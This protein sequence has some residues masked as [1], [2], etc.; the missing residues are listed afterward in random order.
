MVTDAADNNNLVIDISK[1]RSAGIFGNEDGL[2]QRSA[3]R[4]VERFIG[5]SVGK[6]DAFQKELHKD[7]H[8]VLGFTRVHD[9]ILI[10]G[11]RGSGKTSFMHSAIKHL[12]EKPPRPY[13][14][15]KLHSLGVIDPT[16][17]SSREHIFLL[18]ISKIRNAVENHYSKE[19]LQDAS[20]AEKRDW[21]DQL[22]NLSRG[23][24][25]Q[26][27]IGTSPLARTEWEDPG[28]ILAEGLQNAQGGIKLER[29]FHRFVDSS[30]KILGAK[31][32]L[33]GI[34]DTDTDF[35]KGWPVLE[36]LRKFLTTPQLIILLSGDYDMYSK[37]VRRHQWEQFKD[38]PQL[39]RHYGEAHLQSAVEQLE[40]QYLI[41]LL[42]PP[43]RIDLKL[44]WQL[45]D[46]LYIK[47]HSG[48]KVL[49]R[50]VMSAFTEIW[51]KFPQSICK[52][53]GSLFTHLPMRNLMN[54][55]ILIEGNG[56][57]NSTPADDKND[58]TNNI[59][60]ARAHEWAE[61]E[62]HD[63][64]P[65]NIS[66]DDE[67]SSQS[68]LTVHSSLIFVHFG[69]LVSIGF[70]QEDLQA[71]QW[72]G[73]FSKLAKV[74][75]DR[76]LLKHG[77]DLFPA[78]VMQQD[79]IDI[80]ILSGIFMSAMLSDIKHVADYYIRVL[81]VRDFY[82]YKESETNNQKNKEPASD[83][84]N[85]DIRID[86][87]LFSQQNSLVDIG[88]YITRK[89][90]YLKKQDKACK[91]ESKIIITFT[92]EGNNEDN[93]F[94]PKYSLLSNRIISLESDKPYLIPIFNSIMLLDIQTEGGNDY[95]FYFS[96]YNLVAL[97]GLCIGAD[98]GLEI[99]LKRFR[100]P[101][102]INE[103][104]TT[105][106]HKSIFGHSAINY[107]TLS[108]PVNKIHTWA[109]KYHKVDDTHK[110]EKLLLPPYVHAAIWRTFIQSWEEKDKS[111][112]PITQAKNKFL[113]AIK[114]EEEQ[115]RCKDADKD[116]VG[117][118]GEEQ[119]SGKD[120]DGHPYY[121]FVKACPLWDMLEK[122]DTILV[123]NTK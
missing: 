38:H 88:S 114:T 82:T 97:F 121:T 74:L 79:G 92:S 59:T 55:L 90:F 91:E 32:F 84:Q 73:Q 60:F 13:S 116:P 41:K 42:R 56:L 35:G 62:K 65:K 3:L 118:A 45:P 98:E 86:D 52:R 10:S 22:G 71:V 19:T 16:L 94:F 9:T 112:H 69:Q 95:N 93:S 81:L 101:E 49:L 80:L 110:K 72:V 14:S 5:K 2:I 119:S 85:A 117:K 123:P 106:R 34:D 21:L 23:L 11:A 111:T 46:H 61:T 109:S 6:I 15:E 47:D 122:L 29:R 115:Y 107:K 26:D 37:L 8:D 105:D 43:R 99:D 102:L 76:K 44:A 83:S 30:L 67:V 7:P 4:D 77:A 89:H 104:Q 53:I 120:A 1:S 28:F 20:P 103:M 100:Q 63:T 108:D 96:P 68:L 48:K 12:C 27:G 39:I 31:A 78:N 75:Y 33:L 54:L 18:I 50:H 113:D 57:D 70:T 40:A 66:P 58:Q 64:S 25:T 36:I 87:F 17:I 24:C 51:Y